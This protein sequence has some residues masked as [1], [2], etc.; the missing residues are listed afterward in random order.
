LDVGVLA[1]R[2]QDSVRDLLATRTSALYR[3]DALSGALVAFGMSGDVGPSSGRVVIPRGHGAA[4]LAVL[5]R[6]PVATTNI[7]TDPAITLD[8][9]ARARIGASGHRSV[10]SVPLL[11]KDAVVGALSVGDVEGRVFTHEDVQV[12]QTFADQA[13]LA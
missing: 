12:L 8:A 6:R 2:I 13:T 1:E 3:Y 4:G 7:L 10:L 5:Q 9:G 11:V